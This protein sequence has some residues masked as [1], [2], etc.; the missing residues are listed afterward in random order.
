MSIGVK[1]VIGMMSLYLVSGLFNALTGLTKSVTVMSSVLYLLC[2]ATG[3]TGS[4]FFLA[5][6]RAQLFRRCAL[7]ALIFSSL[8]Y[9]TPEFSL[10][11]PSLI[12]FTLTSTSRLTRKEHVEVFRQEGVDLVPLL[13]LSVAW[14]VSKDYVLLER[15][16]KKQHID[17]D[18]IFMPRGIPRGQG[19]SVVSFSG[20]DHGVGYP[21]LSGLPH[22]SPPRTEG[23]GW[24]LDGC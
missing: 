24:Y 1:V 12:S 21:I 20:L 2:I 10:A 8:I 13:L 16:R 19:S 23:R 4:V 14:V 6:R 9:V 15:R 7:A 11:F 3:I 17:A 22:G 18:P 5:S